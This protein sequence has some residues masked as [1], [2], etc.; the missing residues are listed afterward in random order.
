MLWINKDGTDI[1]VSEEEFMRELG[2]D[3]PQ[4]MKAEIFDVAEEYLYD[5][6]DGRFKGPDKSK[7]I[8]MGASCKSIIF[9][10]KAEKVERDGKEKI[11]LKGY[12]GSPLYIALKLKCYEEAEAILDKNPSTAFPGY[13][14]LPVVLTYSIE[15]TT[16]QYRQAVE[17]AL[18]FPNYFDFPELKYLVD[19][20]IYLQELTYTDKEIPDSLF[21]KLCNALSERDKSKVDKPL[22]LLREKPELP[23]Y[24]FKGSKNK[25]YRN[26]NDVPIVALDFP[27]KF[28]GITTK[29]DLFENQSYMKKALANLQCYVDFLD[30]LYRLKKLDADLFNKI[31][32]ET[33]AYWVFIQYY[34]KTIC[35]LLEIAKEE[36]ILDNEV[37]DFHITDIKG[38]IDI[39][40]EFEK[41]RKKF[42]RLGIN[43]LSADVLWDTMESVNKIAEITPV[44]RYNVNSYLL[45]DVYKAVFKDKL[46]F[47]FDSD[48]FNTKDL[49]KLSKILGL[50]TDATCNYYWRDSDAKIDNIAWNV[51]RINWINENTIKTGRKMMEK[52]VIQMKDK[53]FFLA[54]LEKNIFPIW[55]A[56][57]MV[58]CIE[59]ESEEYRDYLPL[60]LLKKHGRFD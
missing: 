1:Q 53:E 12:A 31:F 19:K 3:D 27:D 57:F 8:N 49:N 44:G 18:D 16:P 5:F 50:S 38:D 17:E 52:A 34:Q 39:E 36:D 55:D 33:T 10:T 56:E 13:A 30:G 11:I 48:G 7:L 28:Y 51:D 46:I 14:A 22:T 42:K 15:T 25:D 45:Y 43:K 21:L 4:A 59:S 26:N 58:D 29:P 20:D 32:D 41:V 37:D 60:V 35:V 6:I 2:D 9:F 47:E 54:C 23:A 40:E 24:L